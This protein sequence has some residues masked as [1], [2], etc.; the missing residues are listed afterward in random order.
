M[1]GWRD[2]GTTSGKRDRGTGHMVDVKVLA[3]KAARRERAMPPIIRDS[4]PRVIVDGQARR[5]RARFTAGF[6]FAVASPEA[7]RYAGNSCLRT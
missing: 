2:A 6:T 3:M 5:R 7:A 4:R 1:R